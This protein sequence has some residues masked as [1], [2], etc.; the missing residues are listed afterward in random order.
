MNILL[1]FTYPQSNVNPN[2]SLFFVYTMKVSGAVLFWIPV[3]FIV[4][5]STVIQ[6]IF[7]CGTQNK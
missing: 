1:S 6:N 5:T 3:T 4:G 2:L 7:S